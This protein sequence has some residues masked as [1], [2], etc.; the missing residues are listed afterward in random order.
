[1]NKKTRNIFILFIVLVLL[2]SIY[3]LLSYESSD[4]PVAEEG[5]QQD[6]GAM[7]EKYTGQLKFLV[8]DYR[9]AISNDELDTEKIKNIKNS[10]LDLMVPA[11]Y[12][13]LHVQIVLALV[14][15]EEFVKNKD[16]AYKI[17]S[18]NLINEALANN[19]WLETK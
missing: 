4:R 3:L 1:M 5:I 2:V 13:D 6:A 18:S 14:K 17:E 16:Q 12:R 15:M 9:E 8:A 11:Q 19:S 10:I 7:A